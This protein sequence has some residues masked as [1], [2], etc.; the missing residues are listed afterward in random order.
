MKIKSIMFRGSRIMIS[1]MAIA[2]SVIALVAIIFTVS[3]ISTLLEPDGIKK[4]IPCSC[5]A[6]EWIYRSQ[7]NYF[8]YS[9]SNIVLL[10]ISL[11]SAI[12]A[13]YKKTWLPILISSV[14]LSIAII[15]TVFFNLE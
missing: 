10:V 1:F 8:L 12:R 4:L 2:L 6:D 13:I 3:E 9:L 14:T 7:M 11:C 5:V 15:M